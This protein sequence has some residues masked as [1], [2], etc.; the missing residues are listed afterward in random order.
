MAGLGL[1]GH[2]L[3][4]E[5][6]FEPDAHIPSANPQHGASCTQ[7]CADSAS[8][9]LCLQHV[10]QGGQGLKGDVS[11]L[12]PQMAHEEIARIMKTLDVRQDGEID[13]D[14]FVA[15]VAAEQSKLTDAKLR[16]AFD[17]MDADSDGVVSSGVAFV[18]SGTWSG[19][20][21]GRL[22]CKL[23]AAR[24]AWVSRLVSKVPGLH[25]QTELQH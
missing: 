25:L 13:Y 19:M 23:R 2:E 11:L 3:A 8:A 16:A 7:P 22:R 24:T 1:H 6:I 12:V 4:V 20:K 21:Y 15:S 10:V 14:E 18:V 5:T 9:T 17:Y